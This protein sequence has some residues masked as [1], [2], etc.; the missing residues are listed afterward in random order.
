[1]PLDYLFLSSSTGSDVFPFGPPGK[2][3]CLDICH[4]LVIQF[5]MLI[6]DAST[7]ILLAK[8]S[9]LEIFVLNF[10]GEV[11]IPRKVND[12]IRRG[13]SEEIPFLVKLIEEKNIQ[14]VRVGESRQIKKL[15]MDFNIDSGEAEAIVLALQK[16]NSL[17][18]TDDRNAIRTCKILKINFTTAIAVLI[19]TCE[20]NLIDKKEALLK[21]QRLE[22]VARYHRVIIE[23][24][25]RQI[26]GGDADV[27]KDAEYSSE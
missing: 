6:L 7:L 2:S 20:K 19:R 3:F 9:I 23:D 26:T 17:V 4:L 21:L 16:K 10:P 25:K 27:H 22:T 12:E 18:G 14:V 8:I 15:M 13:K 5:T 24:A 1:M 11:F